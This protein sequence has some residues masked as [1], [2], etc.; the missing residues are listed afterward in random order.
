MGM[1]HEGF[2]IHKEIKLSIEIIIGIKVGMAEIKF[3][4]IYDKKY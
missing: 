2:D 4:P 3:I 1:A